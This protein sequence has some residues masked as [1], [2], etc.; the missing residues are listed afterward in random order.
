MIRSTGSFGGLPGSIVD[1]I[2]TCGGIAARR[3]PASASSALNQAS[4][5]RVSCSRFL[6][7]KVPISQALIGDTWTPRFS[8]CAAV[9]DALLSAEIG[10]L[11]ISQIAAQVS[12]STGRTGVKYRLPTLH[13]CPRSDRCL[14]RLS[15]CLAARPKVLPA[16]APPERSPRPADYASAAQLGRFSRAQPRQ[17][18]PG[19][20]P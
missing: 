5:E 17:S 2:K 8:A 10:S 13:Q 1:A 15:P 20:E 9:I 6:A 12:R 19:S 11:F 4:G 18:G 3:T 16:A 7:T 14:A